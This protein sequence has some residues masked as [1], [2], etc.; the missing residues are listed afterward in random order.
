MIIITMTLPLILAI[1]MISNRHF[2]SYASDD[3]KIS[4][5]GVESRTLHPMLLSI[6]ADWEK[7]SEGLW[8]M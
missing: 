6:A 4:S 3:T 7:E 5:H 8:F 1:D 2:Y